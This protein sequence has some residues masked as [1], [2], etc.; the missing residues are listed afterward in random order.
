M[1]EVEMKKS[2]AGRAAD[3]VLGR[4]PEFFEYLIAELGSTGWVAVALMEKGEQLV[5][6]DLVFRCGAALWDYSGA[7]DPAF[8]KYSPGIMLLPTLI[9]FGVAT[10][11]TKYDFLRGTEPYK[12]HWSEDSEKTCHFQAASPTVRGRLLAHLYF[13]L[14][15]PAY[16]LLEDSKHKLWK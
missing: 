2:I 9:D 1:I 6:Y 4:W 7:Y 14:H 8:A 3:P 16:R 12:L 10:G 11:C 15:R 13:D 5:A